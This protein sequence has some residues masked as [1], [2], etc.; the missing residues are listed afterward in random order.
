MADSEYVILAPKNVE[1]QHTKKDVV[2]IKVFVLHMFKRQLH[3]DCSC[4]QTV[5]HQCSH[6]MVTVLKLVKCIYL[7]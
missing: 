7:Y 4:S 1:R 2:D 3:I 5:Y 6:Q